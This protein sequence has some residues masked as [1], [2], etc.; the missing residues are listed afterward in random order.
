MAFS[1]RSYARPYLGG[2]G[3][4]PGVKGLI[5]ANSVVF[6]LMWLL[7][8]AEPV[9]I[10]ASLFSLVPADVVRRFYVWQLGTYLFLHA[11]FFHILFNMLALWFFGKDLEDIW[12]TRRFLQFYFFCGVG[13]GLFVVLGNYLF[14]NPL[15]PTVGASGAIYGVLLVCAVMWPDRIII[16]YIFPIK[17]KYFVMILAGIA[18]FGLR[19]LNSGVSDVAHLS[20]MLF[21]Y[22]FL[23]SPKI[24]KFDAVGPVRDSY[25]AWKLARAKRKFQVYLKKQ[26]GSDRDRWVH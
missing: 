10:F 23:K 11:G 5:I 22:V 3:L 9:R 26:Q 14:G 25:K 1:T 15:I 18:F 6:L 4:P 8:S 19:D 16:F 7:G 12:G 13:A 24:R 21:G 20:G 17:L 2:G